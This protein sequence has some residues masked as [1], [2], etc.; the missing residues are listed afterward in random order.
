[1]EAR[2]E[3]LKHLFEC[4]SRR[5]DGE[6][7]DDFA[8]VLHGREFESRAASVEDEDDRSVFVHDVMV[9]LLL[10]CC[11]ISRPKAPT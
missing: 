2:D 11:R 10:A 6:G 4:G 1:M 7:F 8:R 5:R 9:L 3:L